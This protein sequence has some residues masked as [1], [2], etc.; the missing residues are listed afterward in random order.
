MIKILLDGQL[1]EDEPS[2]NNRKETKKIIGKDTLNTNSVALTEDA[3]AKNIKENNHEELFRERLLSVK[4][5]E[6]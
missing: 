3:D 2:N 1:D 5:I 6:Q 4:E